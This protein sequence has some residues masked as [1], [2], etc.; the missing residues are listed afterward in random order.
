MEKTIRDVE[1]GQGFVQLL[2][3]VTNKG[4]NFFVERNGHAIAAVVPID[5]YRQWQQRRSRL[6]Q[7]LEQAQ[8]SADLAPEVADRLAKDAVKAIRSQ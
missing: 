8:A 1:V 3:E 2:E 7:R 4:D 6:F 5:V